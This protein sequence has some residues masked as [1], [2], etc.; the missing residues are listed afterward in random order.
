MATAP[1]VDA[2]KAYLGDESSFSDDDVQEALN[3]ETVA[4]AYRCRIPAGDDA[5]PAD[6][7]LALM[8]RVSRNLA[9]KAI[10]LGYQQS[11]TEFGA[12]NTR[13]GSDPEIRRLEG[14]YR[15]WVVG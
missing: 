2:A 10:P 8:R 13:I 7:A 15:R 12:T 4:Q 11:A 3:A 5:Y 14:P 9:M 1:D 6:L